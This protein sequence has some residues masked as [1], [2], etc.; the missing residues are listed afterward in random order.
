MRFKK[1]RMMLLAVPAAAVCLAAFVLPT[2]RA[3]S[4]SRAS[5]PIRPMATIL[6]EMGHFNLLPL[7]D[8]QK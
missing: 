1:V 8:C 6:T 2:L 4:Q 7:E 5:E 3:V